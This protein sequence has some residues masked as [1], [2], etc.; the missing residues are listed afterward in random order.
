M[1]NTQDESKTLLT[2]KKRILIPVILILLL[3]LL[4]MVFGEYIIKFF[5]QNKWIILT[6]FLAIILYTSWTF[7]KFF[8]NQKQNLRR[9]WYFFFILGVVLF[10]NQRGF[11]VNEWQHFTLLAGMFIFVDLALFL[12]PTIK[13][14]GGTEMEQINEVEN[15]NDVMKKIIVQTQNRSLQFTEILDM[16]K[17][18]SFETQEWNEIESYRKSLEDFLFTYG[19]ICRHSI[20]VFKKDKDVNFKQEIGAVLGINITEEQLTSIN[21]KTVIQ[22]NE[23]IALIPYLEKIFPVVISIVSQKEPILDIDVDHVINLS[24]IHSW[25]KMPN[26]SDS[27]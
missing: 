24:L 20:T 14:I 11:N 15:V 12:T 7:K 9:T 25:L 3:F 5:Q 10:L 22:I 21:E 4:N 16:M 23:Q 8:N 6:V 19:E 27:E 2:T 13:K 1:E 26:K 18:S 17:I